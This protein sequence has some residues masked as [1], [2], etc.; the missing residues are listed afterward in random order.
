MGFMAGHGHQ[1]MH[2]LKHIILTSSVLQV[3]PHALVLLRNFALAFG[4]GV[5]APEYRSVFAVC[6]M[7]AAQQ[8]FGG[9]PDFAAWALIASIP[10]YGKCTASPLLLSGMHR[11]NPPE[12]SRTLD[13]HLSFYVTSRDLVQETLAAIDRKVDEAVVFDLVSHL[14]EFA[15]MGARAWLAEAVDILTGGSMSLDGLEVQS[16][17]LGHLESEASGLGFEINDLGFLD[18]EGS[19]LGCQLNDLESMASEGGW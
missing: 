16:Q 3:L 18:S 10:R 8:T 4:D 11:V 19:G 1:L 6:A 2:I 13:A 5:R 17:E 7:A 9:E 14:A 15:A 12:E